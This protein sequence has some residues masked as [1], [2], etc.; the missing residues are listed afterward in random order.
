[1]NSATN[2]EPSPGP[3][4]F[5]EIMAAVLRAGGRCLYLL[6][7]EKGRIE[8]RET[9]HT[10]SQEVDDDL[11][12]PMKI[13]A[14]LMG[15]GYSTLSRKWRSWGLHPTPNGT[16]LLFAPKELKQSTWKRRVSFRGRPKKRWDS[17][18]AQP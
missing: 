9:A 11:P 17:N 6:T 13:A 12:V 15:C 3:S 18:E 4:N 16:R 14:R 8:I 5:A 2:P 7:V 10:P 1:M